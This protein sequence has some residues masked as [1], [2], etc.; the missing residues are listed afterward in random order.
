[1]ALDIN[2]DST[3]LVLHTYFQRHEYLKYTMLAISRSR[4]V[5]WYSNKTLQLSTPCTHSLIPCHSLSKNMNFWRHNPVE[6]HVAH[7]QI[8]VPTSVHTPSKSSIRNGFQLVTVTVTVTDTV[9][10]TISDVLTCFGKG[11][12]VGL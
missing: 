9:T 6:V 4:S 10:D 2:L 11:L 12:R 5:M 8:S 3:I 1:M 7:W